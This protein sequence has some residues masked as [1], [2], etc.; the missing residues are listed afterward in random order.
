MAEVKQTEGIQ[1]SERKIAHSINDLPELP[2][3]YMRVVHITNKKNEQEL[4]DT[5]LNYKKYGMAMSVARAWGKA[6]EV[7]VWSD[8]P[9]FSSPNA[10]ALI[11]D[12]PAEEWKL[13]NNV[14]HC[15][16]KIS[17]DKIVGFVDAV[18]P[19]K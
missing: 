6:N 11:L 12:I 13:H 3:G 1:N 16:G 18:R 4:L 5:G 19:V 9:R 14:V 7:E 17:A 8:D 15:P 10:K 2:D